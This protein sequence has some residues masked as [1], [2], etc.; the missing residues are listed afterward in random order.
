MSHPEEASGEDP[1]HAGETM[2]LGW[3]GN[4]SGPPGRAGGSVWE[5]KNTTFL[6][7]LRSFNICRTMLRMFCE[8]VFFYTKDRDSKSNQSAVMET[9]C[10]IFVIRKEGAEPDNGPEDVG[11]F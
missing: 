10:G 9:T 1:G 8:S 7:R 4:A 3:P 6:R 5:N 11:S 2:S